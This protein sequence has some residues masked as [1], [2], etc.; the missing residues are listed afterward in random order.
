YASTEAG[1]ILINV[2][3]AK[4]GSMGRRLPGSAEVR[5]AAYDLEA[6]GLVLDRDGFAKSCAVDEVG[7]LLARVSP[8]EPLSITPLRSLFARG[9]AWVVTGDLFRRDADGDYWRVDGAGDVI[10]GEQGPVFTTPIR[11][12]LGAVPAI[13]LAAAYGVAR[14]P[15]GHQIAVAAVTLRAGREL[16]AREI[17]RALAVLEREERPALVHVV[18]RIPVTTWFRPV[19]QELRAAG[20]PEPEEGKQAWYLDASGATYRPLTAAARQR[21]M[22]PA[23]GSATTKPGASRPSTA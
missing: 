4:L 8:N 2:R 6:Q 11:D 9:D 17:G 18:D 12:A 20:V 13:D 10:H 16:T 3:G 23:S 5:I 7:M 14:E 21:L 1:A 15:G 22:R 19:T